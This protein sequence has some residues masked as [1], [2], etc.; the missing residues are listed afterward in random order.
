MSQERAYPH[1]GDAKAA[2]VSGAKPPGASS[3]VR[4]GKWRE[5]LRKS[6]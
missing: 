2:G 3:S 6:D 4:M 5:I 1:A